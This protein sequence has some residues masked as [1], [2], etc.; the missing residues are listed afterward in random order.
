MAEVIAQRVNSMVETEGK[1][2]AFCFEANEKGLIY[3]CP[4]GCEVTGF[5]PFKGKDH[6][7]PTVWDFDGN[8]DKPTLTP[9]IQRLSGCKWHGFMTAGIW[10]SC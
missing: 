1:P 3:N 7:Y 6:G 2:G 4:C 9:S 8:L 5:I 10:R